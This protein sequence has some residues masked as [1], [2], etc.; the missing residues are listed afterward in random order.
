MQHT[1][2]ILNIKSHGNITIG[3]VIGLKGL[4]AENIE[5]S[6][7]LSPLTCTVI[8]PNYDGEILS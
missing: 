1:L 5:F 3:G 7:S 6:N 4:T 8:F 2:L